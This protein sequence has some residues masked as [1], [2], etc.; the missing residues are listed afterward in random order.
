MLSYPRMNSLLK[1]L[2]DNNG[3]INS[4]A[5]SNKFNLHL[6]DLAILLGLSRD[7]IKDKKYIQLTA[8]QCRL[9][10]MLNIFDFIWPWC[11]T[12]EKTYLWY[13]SQDIPGF[14]QQTAKQLVEKGRYKDVMHYLREIN[15]G[16]FA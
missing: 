10:E 6:I 14:G 13:V 9:H 8:T 4:V 15:Y 1:E 5:L 2:T 16:S 7:R 11:G 3:Y 12:L